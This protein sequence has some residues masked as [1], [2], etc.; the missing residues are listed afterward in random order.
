MRFTFFLIAVFSSVILSAAPLKLA[1]NGKTDYTIVVPSNASAVDQFAAKELAF[2]LKEITGAVFPIANTAK[3]SA[4]YIG[5][6]KGKNLPDDV[7]MIETSG[8]DLHLYG[9]G[10]HGNLWAVY[11]LLENTFGCMFLNGFGDFYAPKQSVLTLPE[12]KKKTEYAFRARAIMIYFYKDSATASVSHYRNR[13]NLLLQSY[14]HPRDPGTNK[15]IVNLYE[16][17]TSTHSLGQLI[18]AGVKEVRTGYHA[19]T[20]I[21]DALPELKDK[22]YFLTNPEFFSMD[23]KGKRV[24]NRQLCFSNPE[25]RKEL[26]KNVRMYYDLMFKRT[27]LKGHIDIS[28][29]DTAYRL[30]YCQNCMAMEKK[31]GSRGAP[32]IYTMIEL[33]KNNPDITFRTLAYQRTQSQHPPKNMGP[34]PE[35]LIIIFAPINGDYANPLDRGS[36]NKIDFDDFKTWAGMTKNILFWYYPNVYNRSKDTF[37]LEP[38]NGS[39]KRIAR[40]IQLMRD[41]KI[42]GTYFEHDSGGIQLCT[43]FSEMQA[44]I[45]LKLFQNPD[46]N[47][48]SLIEKYLEVY[49][50]PAAPVLK[51]YHGE[52]VAALEKYTSAGGKWHYRM[53][54]AVYLT[55]E[56]LMRWDGMLEEAEKAVSGEYAFRV[57]L[58]RMGLD[59][60]IVA[61]VGDQADMRIAR[62]KQTLQELQNK[63]AVKVNWKAFESWSSTVKNR[64]YE[65]AL[66]AEFAGVPETIVIPVPEKGATVVPLKGANLGRAFVETRAP[67]KNFAM[68]FYD[69]TSKK[70]LGYKAFRPGEIQSGRFDFYL[71]TPKPIQLTPTTLCY[72]GSWRMNYFVGR[73]AVNRDDAE[74]LKQKFYIFVSLREDDGKVYSDRA[75]IVPAEKATRKMLLPREPGRTALPAVLDNV[76]DVIEIPVP[77]YN[78]VKVA[79]PAA[80]FQRALPEVWDGKTVFRMGLYHGK[81]KKYSSTKVLRASD[82]PADGKYHLVRLT[83]EPDT[84]TPTTVFFAGAWKMSF[85]LGHDAVAGVKYHVFISL[86][87]EEGR[88]LG[89][90]VVLVPGEKCPAEL[91]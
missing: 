50:G 68:G 76:A 27:G 25:L 14:N 36:E 12:T 70:Y 90:K 56:N 38:P 2:F 80:H 73:T 62:I 13:Q 65:T 44:W 21:L 1:E 40:D 51:K 17:F 4:V 24:P 32:L 84:I 35:N 71:L 89:D 46:L 19:G 53:I 67:G 34:I 7:S 18:P 60:T 74:S 6:P 54:D 29:N 78:K 16:I 26:Q 11:E 64:G 3:G 61:K 77:K 9:G 57:R 72:G 49:Y 66:P 75:Y 87:R 59:N 15:G 8:K 52:L 55:K 45:M 10:V 41:Q 31:Y 63:R 28:C 81:D 69:Q 86:K 58:L 85:Q 20:G 23:D 79:D 5:V 37:F 43:N 42:L 33:A 39:I 88:L 48:D 83:R 82:V 91:K 22:K 30:C 47:V